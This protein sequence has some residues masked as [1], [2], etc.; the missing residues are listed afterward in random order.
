LA[1]PGALEPASKQ[2]SLK[3]A[4]GNQEA[5]TGVACET[6]AQRVEVL[7]NGSG[8]LVWNWKLYEYNSAGDVV[9]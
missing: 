9:K 1:G 5:T 6:W 2:E 7:V 3:E 4:G 8:L